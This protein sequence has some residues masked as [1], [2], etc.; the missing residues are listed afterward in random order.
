MAMRASVDALVPLSLASR[1]SASRISSTKRSCKG[2]FLCLSS[3]FRAGFF[4][5]SLIRSTVADADN[6]FTLISH[7]YAR[8]YT[9]LGR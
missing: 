7:R 8:L 9:T 2:L 4:L 1:S 5:G 3:T 6:A